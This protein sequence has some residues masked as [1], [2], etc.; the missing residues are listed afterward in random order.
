MVNGTKKKEKKKKKIK[1]KKIKKK[2]KNIKINKSLACCTLN[3][4]GFSF[5][6]TGQVVSRMIN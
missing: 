4:K 6:V 5:D 3:S 2:K 1:K